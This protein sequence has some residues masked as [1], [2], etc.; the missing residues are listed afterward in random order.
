MFGDVSKHIRLV[1]EDLALL[2]GDQLVN[3]MLA[4]VALV[5]VAERAAG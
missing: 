5:P 4:D 1:R 2:H 3:P